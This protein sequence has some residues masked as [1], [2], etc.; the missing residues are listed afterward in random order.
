MKKLK[1]FLIIMLGILSCQQ[2]Q[3]MPNNRIGTVSIDTIIQNFINVKS[4]EQNV[5][6]NI[7]IVSTFKKDT[8]FLSMINSSPDL[9]HIKFKGFKYF[10]NYRIFFVG[11][12]SFDRL[13]TNDNLIPIPED[14][15]EDLR[16][17]NNLVPKNEEPTI[18]EI[19]IK[20]DIVKCYPTEIKKIF[21]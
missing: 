16:H 12:D 4:V 1:L 13:F 17:Y 14:V 6:N 3:K 7:T 5:K 18:W 10:N 20:G 15:G 2:K 11:D 8:I 21:H 19:W 9:E